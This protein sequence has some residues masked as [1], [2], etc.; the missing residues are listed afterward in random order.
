MDEAMW[1]DVIDDD[2]HMQ[3][4][5]LEQAFLKYTAKNVDILQQ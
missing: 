2:T 3:L 1:A 4:C 5:F